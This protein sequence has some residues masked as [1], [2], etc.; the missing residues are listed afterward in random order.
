MDAGCYAIHLLRTLAGAEPTVKSARA[1]LK[2]PGVDRLLEA[3]LE[4][5]DGRTGSIRASLLSLKFVGAGARVI[6]ATG[7]MDALNPFVPQ[8]LHSLT[9]RTGKGRRREKVAKRPSTYLAQLTAFRDAVLH[10]APFPTTA[11]DAIANMRVIDACY[12]AAGMAPRE[13]TEILQ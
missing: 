13:P 2:S 4:F 7:R 9:V 12:R 8:L 11:D 1:K 5:A 10:G 6:G 3:E